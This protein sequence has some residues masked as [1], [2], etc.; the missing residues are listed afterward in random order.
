MQQVPFEPQ[1]PL[2]VL[3]LLLLPLVDHLVVYLRVLIFALL[4]LLPLEL[5]L[6]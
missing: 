3:S 5:L 4:L 6:V 2:F 1:L